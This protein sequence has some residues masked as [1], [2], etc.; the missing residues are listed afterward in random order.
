[1]GQ[2]RDDSA[3]RASIFDL[4]MK[5]GTTGSRPMPGVCSEWAFIGFTSLSS[6]PR[7]V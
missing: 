2:K 7:D 5:P 1:M 4:N 6:P 3:L